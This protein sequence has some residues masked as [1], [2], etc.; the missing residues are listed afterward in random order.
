MNTE[1]SFVVDRA[2]K[3][4][5]MTKVFDAPREL[6]WEVLTSPK[7]LP[8]WWGPRELTTTI[9][10]MDVRVGGE[11][12][13]VQKDPQGNEFAFHGVYKELIP[14][15]KAVQTFNFEPIG[16][17]HELTETMTLEDVDGKTRV[18]T[19]SQ[20]SSSEDLEGMVGSGMEGGSRDSWERA[21]ELIAKLK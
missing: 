18:K 17:G 15:E 12:R 20:F 3:Q 16:P 14:N 9:D 21:A 5:V 13:F 10:K 19:V 7:H 8:N 4:V 11:W 2:Q 6:V 1:T